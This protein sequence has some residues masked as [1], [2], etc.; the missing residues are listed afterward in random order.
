MV[1]RFCSFWHCDTAV[2]GDNSKQMSYLPFV[3]G[4][5]CNPFSS[6]SHS[7]GTV[8]P[9]VPHSTGGFHVT[10]IKGTRRHDRPSARLDRLYRSRF[11]SY[12]YHRSW[13]RYRTVA[14]C[15]PHRAETTTKIANR[16]RVLRGNHKRHP[17]RFHRPICRQ[18]SVPPLYGPGHTEPCT[19]GVYRR[20]SSSQETFLSFLGQS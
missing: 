9:Q 3:V 6:G 16:T 12:E 1:G 11:Y 8:C 2:L 5:N 17:D 13:V 14:I 18:A 10:K 19:L 7:Q 15:D 4:D 20:S